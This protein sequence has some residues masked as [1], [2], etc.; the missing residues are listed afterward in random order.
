MVNDQ[1]SSAV[2]NRFRLHLLGKDF[3]QERF[4]RREEARDARR[5]RFED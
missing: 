2:L 1:G 3:S 5:R 4:Q